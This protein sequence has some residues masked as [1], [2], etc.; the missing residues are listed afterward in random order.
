MSFFSDAFVALFRTPAHVRSGVSRARAQADALAEVEAEMEVWGEEQLSAAVAQRRERLGPYAAE[1]FVDPAPADFDDECDHRSAHAN[2]TTGAHANP[3]TGVVV[4]NRCPQSWDSIAEYG[5]HRD[6]PSDDELES[7]TREV[8]FE[9]HPC[10][11]CGGPVPLH[12]SVL[13]CD[14]CREQAR[15]DSARQCWSCAATFSVGPVTRLGVR[16]FCCPK[17]VHPLDSE[18]VSTA[19]EDLF[20]QISD[21]VDALFHD[22]SGSAVP[23][24]A[25][26]SPEAPPTSGDTDPGSVEPAPLPG[27]RWVKAAV[28]LLDELIDELGGDLALQLQILLEKVRARAGEERTVQHIRALLRMEEE[29]PRPDRQAGPW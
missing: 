19:V 6:L 27:D 26:T 12:Y 23:P 9:A 4:C 1:R 2:P 20:E 10:G 24:A 28:S 13:V 8:T 14:K 21:T 17:C 5:R 16:V 29:T 25:D 11:T 7:A 22:S 18:S 15:I 3:T